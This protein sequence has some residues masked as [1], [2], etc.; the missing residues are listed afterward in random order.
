ME[1]LYNDKL[2]RMIEE[3]NKGKVVKGALELVTDALSK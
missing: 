2:D 1:N 3:A